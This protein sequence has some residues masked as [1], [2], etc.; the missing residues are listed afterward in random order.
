MATRPLMQPRARGNPTPLP[1]AKARQL[2]PSAL[3]RN[4]DVAPMFLTR[5]PREVLRIIPTPRLRFWASWLLF[6]RQPIP[7]TQPRPWRPAMRKYSPVRIESISHDLADLHAW[8][9]LKNA[10]GHSR[11]FFDDGPATLPVEPCAPVSPLL[12]GVEV[13]A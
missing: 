6:P 8:V 3:P 13:V 2:P 1:S 9:A 11:S 7:P 12:T 10:C 4:M 5:R